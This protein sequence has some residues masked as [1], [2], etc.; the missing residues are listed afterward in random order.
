MPYTLYTLH[1]DTLLDSQLH[2]SRMRTVHVRK[3]ST[4]HSA[5][6]SAAAGLARSP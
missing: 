6:Y 2:R 4:G 1:T 3:P 5:L